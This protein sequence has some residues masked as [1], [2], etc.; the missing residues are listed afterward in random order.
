MKEPDVVTALDL[1]FPV[2][3][4]GCDALGRPWCEACDAEVEPFAVP[5]PPGIARAAAAA[6]YASG[7]GRALRRAKY[8]RDRRAMVRL[9]ARFALAGAPFAAGHEAIVPV[10][11]PWTRV[12]WRGFAAASLLARALGAAAGVPVVDALR[13]A[14]GGRQAGLGAGG[15]A[16]NLAGRLRSVRAVPGRV[17]VVDDVLTTGTTAAAA[18]RELLG[19]ASDR[20]ELLVLC[21]TE[22][23]G[24][25]TE[26][27]PA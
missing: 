1:L 24:G 13:L 2:R 16:R 21:A 6:D 20:V 4:P 8:G 5:A 7:A 22:R 11:S 14:P 19:A 10:P 26:P 3:C 17:L 9:A 25:A 18:A 23:D 15:R 12:G 27:N